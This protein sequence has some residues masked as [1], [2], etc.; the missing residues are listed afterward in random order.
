MLVRS[1]EVG[2]LDDVL[3]VGLA[4]GIDERCGVRD[5]DGS[6]SVK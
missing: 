4:I 3:E 1:N 5:V 2:T 6:R